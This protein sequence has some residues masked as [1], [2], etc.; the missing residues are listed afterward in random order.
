MRLYVPVICLGAEL[1]RFSVLLHRFRVYNTQT[2]VPLG[3]I[4]LEVFPPMLMAC[5]SPMRTAVELNSIYGLSSYDGMD[6]HFIWIPPSASAKHIQLHGFCV[7][8]SS[9]LSGNLPI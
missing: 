7:R 3:Y 1:L 6:S 5:Q 8:I 2:S 4:L 9:L